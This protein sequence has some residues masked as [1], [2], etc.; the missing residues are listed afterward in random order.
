MTTFQTKTGR[1]STIAEHPDRAAIELA[2]A[3][4][5][6]QTA[7][8]KRY[9]IE[10]STLSR[11]RRKMDSDLVKRLRVRPARTD[12]ELAHIRELESK[13]LLDHLVLIRGR[14]Y[15]NADRAVRIGDDAGERAALSEAGKASERIA[16]L[17]GE[18]GSVIRHD[19]R[20]LHLAA[21]PEWHAVRT[22]LTRALR[23]YPQAH[24]AVIAAL[25]RAETASAHGMEAIAQDSARVL[26]H[27]EA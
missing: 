22:E 26:E 12:E 9:G 6:S 13:S 2:L 20:H 10:Q 5:V 8:S 24:A 4:G 19:H 3:N 7:L 23:P 17:L 18:M 14:L 15:V 16:K 25:Q 1:R 21:S 27:I 11:Y